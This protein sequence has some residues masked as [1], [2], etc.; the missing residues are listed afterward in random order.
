MRPRPEII[1]LAPVGQLLRL[2]AMLVAVGLVSVYVQLHGRA[3]LSALFA[4]ATALTGLVAAYLLSIPAH[5]GL[6]VFGFR[7]FGR[8][9]RG[10]TRVRWRGLSAYTHCDAQVNV[11]AYR[12]SVALP[13]VALG[14]LPLSVGLV[15]GSAVVSVYGAL[16]SASALGDARVLFTLRRV[17]GS[18]LIQFNAE[19]GGFVI[20]RGHT[21]A[22]PE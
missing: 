10:T 13:G 6:H 8:A 19:E 1:R 15:T 21:P 5:E 22:I 9:P 2:P 18:A 11:S 20:E 17:P 14:L 16:L 4:D 3:P 12:R 7:R